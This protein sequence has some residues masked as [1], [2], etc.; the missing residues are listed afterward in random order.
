MFVQQAASHLRTNYVKGRFYYSPNEWPPYHPKHYT[1][2]VLIHHK[3]RHV[4]TEVISVAETLATKGNLSK[5][6]WPSNVNIGYHSKNISELFPNNLESSYF[7]LI[8]GAPGIGKT[9][10]SKEIAYQWAEKRLL[11]FHK[12]SFLLLLRDPNVK[13][14]RSLE[15]LI[16]YLFESTEITSSL[17]KFLFQSKGKGLII[18]LDGYDEMSE[19]D[20]DDSLVAK[21]I[22]REVLPEC[23]LVIT[24]RPS[25]S[26]CLR[27]MADCRV[28]VLGFTEEDR[29]NFIQHAL[30]GSDDKIK[31]LQ[32]YL[33]SNSTINALCYVPLNMTILLCLFEEVN[34]LPCSSLDTDS[35]KRIGL[36]NTQTEMYE[37]FILMTITRF[38]KRENKCFVGRLLKISEIPEPYSKTFNELLHLAY[39]ALTKDEIVFYL[40]EEIVQVCPILKSG[41]W[42][43]LGLLKVIEYVGNISFHYLHFSIQEYLAAYYI[44]LQSRNFQLQLLKDTF[45]NIRYFNTWIMYVGITSGK[46]LAWKHFISGNW[47]MLSTKM[48]KQSKISKRYLNDKIKALHLFQCFAEIGG[49]E[50]VKIFKDKII[51]LSNQTLLPKDVNTICFFLLRSV[52]KHW[53][54]LDL[55]NCNIGD[56]GSDIFIKTFLDKNRDI[57][58]IDKVDLS[59]N[60]LQVHS[61]LALLDTFKVWHTS[62]AVISGNYYDCDCNLFEL[63][64]NKFSLFSDEDFS[65]MVQIDPFLFAHNIEFQSSH[66]NLTNINGLYLNCCTYPSTTLACKELNHKLNL[67]KFHIIGENMNSYHT[68]S[69]VQTIMEVS[70]VYIYNHTLSDEDVKYISLMLCKIRSSN[71]G[72][73]IVIGGTM[74]LGNIP[75]M[76]AL[77]K[78]LSPTEIVNLAESVKRLCSNPNMSATK[79]SECSHLESARFLFED[80]FYL[81]QKNI[82]KCEINFCLVEKNILIANQTKYDKLRKEISSNNNLM[83]V[84]I[85][86]CK[87]N[88]A[89][90]K[91]VM[92]LLSKQSPLEKFYIFESSLEMHNLKY[93]NLL[94]H[95]SK[96]KEL[97]MHTTDSSCTIIFDLLEVQRYYPNISILLITNNTLIGHNPT[98]EQ[99]LLSL[100]LEANLTIWKLSKFQANN[101]LFQQIANAL[102]NVMDLDILG[103]NICEYSLQQSDDKYN[104]YDN[105]AQFLPY[106]TNLKKLNLYH[107]CLQGANAGK[108][109]KNLSINL[110]KLSISYNEINEEVIEDLV[111]FLC[112]N[113]KLEEFIFNCNNL[114]MTGTVKFFNEMKPTSLKQLNISNNGLNDTSAYGIATNLSH[115]A[116]LEELDLS[117]NNLQVTGT[118]AICEGLSNLQR[119]TKL[120]ISNNNISGE[121][122]DKIAI[123]LS[124]NTLLQEINFSYNILGASGSLHIFHNMRKLSNLTKL[125]VCGIG[126]TCVAAKDIVTILNN[127]V[128]LKELNLS[129]NNIQAIGATVIF[130]NA[131]MKNLHKFNISHN[132]I[133][134]NVEDVENFITRNTNLEELD[135][136]HNNVQAAGAIKICRANISKLVVF[137]I[138]HNGITVDAADD[139][140]TFLSHNTELQKLDLSGNDLQAIGYKT[141]FKSFQ[142]CNLISLNIS[143]SSIIKEAAD[144]L[145]TFLH[146]NGSLQELDLT[147][148]HLPSSD[149]VKIYSGMKNISNL[150]TFSI[151]QN[152]NTDKAI[153]ELRNILLRNISL[154]EIDLSYSNMSTSD[155]VK[156]LSGM[157][158]TLNLTAINISHNMITD[159]A[160][161]DIGTVLSRNNKLQSLNLSYN[162]FRSEGFVKIFK[163]LKN[164]MYLRK[165]NISSNDVKA[166]AADSIATVLSHNSKLEELDLGNNLLQTVGIIIIFKSLRQISSLKKICINGNMIT[167][168]A[169]DDIAVVLSQN[170]K[171]EILD[172]SFNNL[173][174]AGAIRIFQVIKHISPLTKL[175]IAH[176]MFSDE[177]IQYIVDALFNKCRL[178]ELNLSHINLKNANLNEL[179]LKTNNINKQF[180][181]CLSHCTNLQVLDLS[182]TNLQDPDAEL[183]GELNLVK[184]NVSGNSITTHAANAIAALLSKNDELEELDVSYNNLQEFGIRNVLNSLNI[185]NLSSLN[186]SNNYI[187]GDLKY[188]ADIL[189]AATNLVELDLSYNNLSADHMKYFLYKTK[190]IFANLVKLNASGNTISDGT[191]TALTDVLSD[192][193]ELQE[194]D[195]SDNNLHAKSIRKI[196]KKLRISSLT[197]LSI[198][199]NNITDKVADKIATFLTRNT[200]LE[201]LDLSHNNLQ[202]AGASRICKTNLSK[203]I[204]FNI[205]HNS[206]T[207][208]AA[209]DIAAFLSHNNKLQFLDLSGN[210][211]RESDSV[212]MFQV[213]QN[214]SVLSSLKISNINVNKTVVDELANILLVNPSL[215]ELDLSCNNLST[216]DSIMIFKGMKNLSSLFIINISHNMIAN[217]AANEFANVLLHN[218]TLQE[219]DISYNTLSTL[220]TV[221]ILRGM[222]NI[223]SLLAINVNYNDITSEAADELSTVL[224]HN[225]SLQ[226]FDL[227]H[228]NLS[229]SDAARIFKG[230]KNILSLVK[231][232]ISHNNITNKAADDLATVLL[233]NTLLQELDLSCNNLS[234]SDTWKIF[235]G[236]K[237]ISSLVR[238][239]VSHNN[240]TDKA[241]DELA[242]VLHHNISLQELELSH[243]NIST[244]DAEKIFEGMRSM[245]NLITVSISHNMITDEVAEKIAIILSR[246]NKLT[247]LD[248][249]S[250]FFRS[251]GFVK[252]FDGMKSIV[253]L[254]KLNVGYNQITAF[255]AV[256]CIADFLFHNTKLEGIVLS[257]VF[258]RSAGFNK[259]FKS[260]KNVFT[261]KKLCIYCNNTNEAADEMAIVLSHN[262]KLQEL[263]ICD[264]D[265]QTESAIKIFQ[266]I[267]SIST[268]TKLNIAHNMFT[269]EATEYILNILSNN[270]KLKELTLSHNNIMISDFTEFVFTGLEVLDLSYTNLQTVDSIGSLKVST[271]KKCNISGNCISIK[272]VK[273]IAAFLSKNDGLQEL[274][275]SHN[276]LQGVG[277]KCI[278]K[279]LNVSSLTKLNI[280]NNNVTGGLY[281]IA[282]AFTH[283]TKLLQLDLSYNKL[284]SDDIEHFLYKAKNIFVN[285]I[286]LNLSGNKIGN[287]AATALANVLSENTKLKELCLSH[288]D[289]QIEV[290]KIFDTL[291]FPSLIKLSLSYNCITDE[292]AD[293]IATFL[294]TSNKL[295]ELDLSYNNLTS[296]GAVAICRTN[297]SKLTTFKMN[298]NSISIQAVNDI[299]AFLA[300]NSN[301]QVLDL[302]NNDL[303]EL[304]S[305]SIFTILRD[306]SVLSTLNISNCNVINGAADEL[307]KALLHTNLLQELH[308][309]HNNLSTP[310]IVKIFNGMKSISHLLKID[311]SHNIIT[312]EAAES[313]AT[314]LSQNNKL[315]SLNLSCNCFRSAGLVKIFE[316][317]KNIMY[318][319]KLNISCNEIKTTA[320]DS[321]AT[322]LSHNSKLEEFYIGNNFMHTAGIIIIFKSLRQISSLKKLY[323][324]GNMITDAAADDIAAV[325]S[326]NTKLEELDISCNNLQ[327]T[328]AVMIFEAIKN[329]STIKKLN[330]SHNMITC[331]AINHIAAVSSNTSK[332]VDLNLSCTYLETMKTLIVPNLIKFNCSNTN[333]DKKIAKEISC[334]LSHCINLQVVDLSYANLQTTG[335]I[336]ELDELKIFTLKAISLCGNLIS[337]NVADKIVALLSDSDDLE[338]LDLSYNNLQESGI[339]NI[340]KSIC[341][342]N[343]TSL[344][345]SNNNITASL[346]DIANILIG[347]T[348]LVELDLSYNKI[349]A[350]SKDCSLN[351]SNNI[352]KNLVKCNISGNKIDNGTTAVILAN[353]LSENTKLKELD[354]SDNNLYAEKIN[355][356]FNK[357]NFSTLIRFNFC[358]NNI[359]DEAADDVA[360]FLSRNKNLKLL[361]LSHNNLQTSGAIKIFR[362]T[363]AKLTTFNISHNSIAIQAVDDLSNFLSNNT[364]LEVLD[365]SCNDLQELG[366]TEICRVLHSNFALSSLKFSN[367]SGIKEAVD[368][369][370]LVLSHSILLQD[371]DLSYNYLS[372]SDAIKTF[373]GMKNIS[374]LVSVNISHNMITDEA[375]EAIGTVLSHN[376]KLQSLDLSYNYFRSEGFGKIF[377][378]LKN[379]MYLRKL[380]ICCN[381]IDIIAAHKIA[382]VLSHTSNL[383]EL[384]LGKNL[385]KTTGAIIIFKSL[386][387]I[388]SL[389]RMYINGNVITDEAADAISAVLSRNI[390]LEEFNISH[391]NLQAAGI[392][393]IFQGIKHISTLTKLNIAYNMINAAATEYVVL[394]LFNNPR[395][396]ELN[397]N[398]INFKIADSFKNIKLTNLRSFSFRKNNIDMQS[399]KK[400]FQFLSYCTNLQVL[401][402]SYTG[403]KDTGCIEVLTTLD[404]FNLVKFNV[405]GNSITT[406]AADAIAALLSKNDELEEL[407]VSYNNLQEFGIRN[408]LDSLNIFNLSSLNISNNYITGDLKYI[409]DILTAATNLVELDLSYNNLSA[410]HMKYFLYKTKHI[411]ANL[412]KLNASGN[413]ISDGTAT[414]LTDV[415][416]DNVELQELDLSDNNLHAKSVRK[417]FKKLRISS[418]IKLSISHN[419]ITDKV[420]DKIAT[421]LTRNTRLE[422]LDLSH[423]NLQ[424]AGASRICKTNLSKLITFNISHNSITTEAADD[425]AAFL[426]HNSKLQFLDL[427]GNNLRELGYR[428]IFKIFQKVSM[429]TSLKLSNC[430]IINKAADELASV[431][432]CNHKLEE[433]DLSNN[434]LWTSDVIK[435]FQGMK[436]I[437][438]FVSINVSHNTIT[439]K[440]ADHLSLVLYY[441]P[442][443]EMLDLSHSKLST[444]GVVNVFRGMKN[445]SNLVSFNF[446]HNHT[447]TADQLAMFISSNPKLETLDLS[448]NDLSASDAVKV[449]ES[450]KMI[451]NLESFK[452]NHNTI[453]N[454]GADKLAA[455]LLDTVS[456]KEI[457]LSHNN[458]TSSGAVTIFT[459][460][461]NISKL[462]VINIGHNMIDYGADTIA[463]TLSNNNNLQILDMSFNHLS[464]DGYIEIFNGMKNILYLRSLVISHNKINFKA[465]N[466]IAT[467]LSQ[468]TKLEELDVSYND[469]QTSGAVAICQGVKYASNL[470]RLIISHNMITD[471]ATE[472]IIDLLCSHSKLKNLNLSDNSLLEM[473]LIAKII[474]GVTKFSKSISKASIITNVQELNFSS[475]NLRTAGTINLSKELCNIT[476]L[477]KF[478]ISG[479]F[480]TSLAADDLANFLSKCIKLQEL[481]LSHN[482]LQES[483]ITR[484]LGAIK[485]TNLF[486]LNISYNNANLETVIELVSCGTKL[487]DLNLSCNVIHFDATW[488][489][490]KSQNAFVNLSKLN[491]SNLF[492]EI[493]DEAATNLAYIFSQNKEL[494]ELNLSSNNINSEAIRRILSKLNTSALIALNVSHNNITDKVADDLA[495]FLS[496]CAKLEVLDLSHNSLQDA[497]VIEI[498]KADI[499]SLI[500]FDISCNN[501]SIKA[502]DDVA[503]FLSHNQ[504]MQAF[505]VCCNG[506][507]EVGVKNIFVDMQVIQSIFNLSVLNITN[508]TN[509]VINEVLSELI[510]ILLHNT[511]LREFYMSY[512]NLSTSNAVK[513]LRGMKNI[514]NLKAF[515]I[516]HNMITDEAA[517]EL[518]SVLLHNTSLKEFSL[519]CNNLSIL[520]AVNIFKGMKEI[521]S[522]ET[523]N[524]SN[525][526]ITDKA[527]EEL[528]T[529]LLH[530]TSLQNVD[531]SYNDLSTSDA[532][533]IFKGM[534]NI[535]N[536]VTINLNNNNI[537]DKATQD[538]ATVLLHNTS[539]QNLDLSYNDLSTS[540]AVNIFKGMKNISRLVTINLSNNNI[541]NEAIQD[542]ATV[543]LHN[544]SLQKLDVSYNDLPTLD[545]VNLFKGLKY[546]ANL[547][548]LNISHNMIA[549]DAADELA[550]VLSHNNNLQTFDMSSN[551]FDSEG[552]IK[553]MNGM[554]N[555]L[556]LKKIDTSYNEITYEAADSIATVLSRNSEL[557]ELALSCNDLYRTS[558]FKRINTT[559]LTK[560]NISGNDLTYIAADDIATVLMHN[561]E[562]EEINMSGND[563]QLSGIKITFQGMK[564]I[565]KLKR[566]DI[567]Y[568]WITC[569]AADDIANVLSQNHGLQDLNLSS[570]HLQTGGIVTLL[571]RM[572]SIS[573]ITHLDISSNGIKS[574]AARDIANFLLHNDNLKV[575]NLSSNF[576]QTSGVKII[577]RNSKLRLEKLNLSGNQLD[578]NAA[579]TIATF[580]SQNLLLEELDLSK[581]YLQA[582]SAVKIFRAIQNCPS[583]LKLNMSN[584]KITDEAGDEIAAVLSTVTKLQEVD[585][586]CN[587]LS[588]DV[589]ECIKRVFIK[590]SSYEL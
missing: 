414:A 215:K 166:T 246:N 562:L 247:S 185:L 43:G 253:C 177:A 384:D 199:H 418:L 455:I 191:A 102:Y 9:V 132:N 154:Q 18:I 78:W 69:I 211:F 73:W 415:L 29:L 31:A 483:G 538:L 135:F 355:K 319:R 74:I 533:N 423:N 79:F 222:M 356:I 257:N 452:F 112:H 543:L 381:E 10:L 412:V 558:L 588:P 213:L 565:L 399:I 509:T 285:L 15:S 338:E 495:I 158:N 76:F 82:L 291:R 45:W 429:L 206:I 192:N 7:L 274:N 125:D 220:D 130:K 342:S 251:K 353:A 143:H 271:L 148:N 510:T 212:N 388:S 3:G 110:T 71:L 385:M 321:I 348:K 145:A 360:T 570:N 218:T 323:I 472:Y 172:I 330:I 493:S 127:N 307:S 333:I 142:M 390:K 156:L 113:P 207:T 260:M 239:N 548:M 446:S 203:L 54:R 244:L 77:D 225:T 367:N 175:N 92:N 523:I 487:V 195:L 425:I 223:S 554:H 122:A 131:L 245:S 394:G 149:I 268:L 179:D 449:F 204:A 85:R 420:A 34:T 550:S 163:C 2:L 26:L 95:T 8:E 508:I 27:N 174:A 505:N 119:L 241:A 288:T 524:L 345:I 173:Q 298:C 574:A 236:M 488:P 254:R 564:N 546:A 155:T 436:N 440:A 499:S 347:A 476:G 549:D 123:V 32:F 572:H 421:F 494:K 473:D 431:L 442:K 465:A 258:M 144:E 502:A 184:F 28:E 544:I 124:Q 504:Q 563:L 318:L 444:S 324:N 153:D 269:N 5:R 432:F 39:N 14:L 579:C 303:Q 294:S 221:K 329:I 306:L 409:A 310:D 484:I 202:A 86:K 382:P 99:I 171:L 457:D 339:G 35:I 461:K 50:L 16:Q 408:I 413:T 451:S 357:L 417:I 182:Y 398:H 539:L 98:N 283:A 56:I 128:G 100:Q 340:L 322:V 426:S 197:K 80:F 190:H 286:N 497:G 233:H 492:H 49:K 500:S 576:I 448:Y 126:I 516:N 83:C 12:L 526:N 38:I 587:L 265:L 89:E 478:N 537:T 108:I 243:N 568:N 42:E 103:Y 479:N 335:G 481:D 489:F 584:N 165:L 513:I 365:L 107:N 469:L 406:H 292:A 485:I 302:S 428:S 378:C 578:D 441:N 59:H 341:I 88:A 410:D 72:V 491:M 20:K 471:E 540:D 109:F 304:D 566:V 24:S 47:F 210:D 443:L 214:M 314:V 507:L 240:I 297:L 96:L 454:V 351:S 140:G 545:A 111:K 46:Q 232:N 238:L 396:K 261:L 435:I 94:N 349:G 290:S 216:S 506:L 159:E 458:L 58:Y 53:I 362:A 522:L 560:L 116:Q 393:K 582:V 337:A 200:K 6:R 266:S 456:L 231:I 186:I 402:L 198:S 248:L 57:V 40:N 121:A 383:E 327:A 581:N 317:L 434:G 575:L 263:D 553:I 528:A 486:K 115:Y 104:H 90:L 118:S 75:D 296:A 264:N 482:D 168:E 511:E 279:C 275:L 521:S 105:L 377:E 404:I 25:A 450:M 278:L 589:S 157:T 61:V 63:C 237:N 17:S 289:L 30:E 308:L 183:L 389:K 300:C 503:N 369:L 376:N 84:L 464:S 552:C 277:I 36:P 590:L 267:K 391:N 480:I 312:N 373:K 209:D 52:N 547:I 490:S 325:L 249:S 405:S 430:H 555:I 44:S 299:A 1:T 427:S 328:S 117:F 343:L 169:A 541:S 287:G 534:K 567:S 315:Q 474:S 331:K 571:S 438:N 397:L 234:T 463:T 4:N 230:M 66:I 561:T 501:I 48:S 162:Y 284:S 496:E 530:N 395:L 252:I 364:K 133:N 217:E 344:N 262:T 255:K 392:I 282:D 311:I 68:G 87:L 141:L 22:R 295:E 101:E 416:S 176:N 370:A 194:L 196:F 170:T 498:C 411:F 13:H 569:E 350:D 23:D 229:T 305:R 313:I 134:D 354:L 512:N 407:D 514:S 120:N 326:Q 227:S 368:E 129:H 137:N 219:F 226:K 517:D 91:T 208:K 201:N 573:K 259:I 577:F 433:L 467:V 93:Q 11:K 445:I 400:M 224:L 379:I 139:I 346:E 106:C 33:Q 136:S 375:A 146:H 586:D 422:N 535:S 21:I 67:S 19:E 70:S 531:L 235:K 228:N 453:T 462:K 403:L 161:E 181:L 167:D 55:S 180:S 401:D 372:T 519:S 281:W 65:L 37:K 62:E 188:I 60:Q 151:S 447:I 525:N 387:H 272:E 309:S 359:T 160:A 301:L 187:T 293:I 193:A 557:E 386:K 242:T 419:N 97:F 460:M 332:L 559:K 189:T 459:G 424:A 363:L 147:C 361:D 580:I 358:C 468:N 256:Q 532:V 551:Y 583:M 164:I 437:S 334:F 585:L 527:T 273:G 316:H 150:V 152:I 81:L 439:N 64:L 276:N 380:N 320:A 41:N 352:F 51:D 556:H 138:S 477:T 529:F 178:K 515:I 542:L 250:N 366:F 270:R 520:D 371:L 280:S 518:A 536:L 114:Q 466:N 470:T 374:N 336:Y 475:I 205:S